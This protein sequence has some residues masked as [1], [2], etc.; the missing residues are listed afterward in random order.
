M[1]VVSKYA[2]ILFLSA[3]SNSI[4]SQEL[5]VVYDQ[6]LTSVVSE[7]KNYGGDSFSFL[8]FPEEFNLSELANESLSHLKE[9]HSNIQYDESFEAFKIF[10]SKHSWTLNKLVLVQGQYQPVSYIA[11]C[12]LSF[13]TGDTICTFKNNVHGLG[14]QFSLDSA[15]M[16]IH[17][18]VLLGLY[19]FVKKH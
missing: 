14:F 11:S 18:K 7:Y 17:D 10:R 4:R 8:V 15:N 6:Q 9:D 2:S 19:K 16:N 1:H 12:R 3:I 13:G 5:I